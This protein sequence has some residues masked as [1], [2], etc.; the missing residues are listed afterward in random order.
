MASSGAARSWK[1]RHDLIV[2]YW[3]EHKDETNTEI[4]RAL[5][6][7]ERTVARHLSFCRRSHALQMGKSV[8]MSEV[9]HVTKGEEGHI[10]VQMRK[11]D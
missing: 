3:K 5:G 1:Q 8:T 7:S 11:K 2:A 4:A 9:W 10:G 6:S